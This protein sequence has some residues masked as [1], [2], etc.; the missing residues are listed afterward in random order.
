M[1]A[2]LLFFSDFI[3]E[4][5]SLNIQDQIKMGLSHDTLQQ[6]PRYIQ[7]NNTSR[8]RIEKQS[9]AVRNYKYLLPSSYL[10]KEMLT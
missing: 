2:I 10:L 3:F 9:F 4:H 7:D 6:I 8:E 5:H 1:T